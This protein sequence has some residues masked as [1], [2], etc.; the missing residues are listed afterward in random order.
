MVDEAIMD[1]KLINWKSLKQGLAS[2]PAVYGSFW[3]KVTR[4]NPGVLEILSVMPTW[5]VLCINP[6]ELQSIII[7][8][9]YLSNQKG[10][11][12][13]FSTELINNQTCKQKLGHWD[14]NKGSTDS[15]YKIS[16]K[17]NENNDFLVFAILGM[18]AILNSG[19]CWGLHLRS[20]I[21]ARSLLNNKLF[22][23][24]D[25][26]KTDRQRNTQ[27]TLA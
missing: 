15:Q 7:F 19:P 2:Y 11:P 8:Y 26:K 16:A 10:W 3:N 18:A 24:V 20:W 23:I 27:D 22:L 6:R 9:D 5:L 4:I 12:K 17:R 1:S 14:Q 21:K 13:F 25:K